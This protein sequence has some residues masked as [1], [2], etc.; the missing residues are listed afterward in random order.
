MVISVVLSVLICP[1]F[2][3]MKGDDA[4]VPAGITKTA[5]TVSD[6]YVKVNKQ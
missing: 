4:Q 5:Y 6:V 2:L 3:L 1:L